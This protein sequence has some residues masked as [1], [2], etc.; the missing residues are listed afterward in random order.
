MN[1]IL[2]CVEYYYFS[3]G[4]SLC[5][6]LSLY[7]VTHGIFRVFMVVCKI[8]TA[9]HV[10][11][12]MLQVTRG[13]NAT[14]IDLKLQLHQ[15][16]LLAPSLGSC[17]GLTCLRELRVS[18]RRPHT[19]RGLTTECCQSLLSMEGGN[20]NNNKEPPVRLTIQCNNRAREDSVSTCSSTPLSPWSTNSSSSFFPSSSSS[21]Q[22][23]LS[24]MSTSPPMSPMPRTPIPIDSPLFNNAPGE[25][26]RKRYK[27]FS[28]DIARRARSQKAMR[29]ESVKKV[30]YP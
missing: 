16:Y 8:L 24:P 14:I 25:S 17:P 5:F 10:K 15:Q 18:S 19:E 29:D 6:S 20:N 7:I 12:Q 21:C 4:D 22:S 3:I 27:S 13:K 28:R 9:L 1:V 26:R 11:C 30:L 23:S 2:D